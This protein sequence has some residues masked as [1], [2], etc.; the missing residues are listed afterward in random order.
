[1]QRKAETVGSSHDRLSR[2]ENAINGE[3]QES[4]L[5]PDDSNRLAALQEQ[6]AHAVLTD[7]EESELES[8][9]ARYGLALHERRM[10][11]LARQRT[12]SVEQAE[13]ESAAEL[14]QAHIW[15]DTFATNPE[16]EQI[17]AKSAA[18]LR[19]QWPG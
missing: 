3:E 1:M 14:E 4:V 19:E 15:W 9:V 8:L 16:R 5:D 17:I 18:A 11:I 10:R 6:F 12:I 2:V 13:R 7:E